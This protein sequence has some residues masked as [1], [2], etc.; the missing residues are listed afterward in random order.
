MVHQ[1]D[2][3]A[4]TIINLIL[5]G[6]SFLTVGFLTSEHTSTCDWSCRNGHQA[7]PSGGIPFCPEPSLY[8]CEQYFTDVISSDPCPFTNVKK[9]HPCTLYLV[10][11]GPEIALSLPFYGFFI[12]EVTL[13]NITYA[14]FGVQVVSVNFDQ[15]R[16]TF[17]PLDR[18]VSLSNS[19]YQYQPTLTF[20]VDGPIGYGLSILFIESLLVEYNSGAFLLGGLIIAVSSMIVSML[21]VLAV[22]GYLHWKYQRIQPLDE[23]PLIN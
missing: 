4:F 19:G 8:R 14:Q 1:S 21:I 3:I 11:D 15:D 9:C 2:A 10:S 20:Q 18:S 5:T 13:N 23:Q 16:H 12:N 6:A 17:S 7:C 22:R